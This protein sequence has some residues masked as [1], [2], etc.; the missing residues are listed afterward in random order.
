MAMNPGANEAVVGSCDHGLKVIDVDKVK[1]KRELY[2]KKYGHAEWVTSVTYTRDGRVLS[3]GMD[4]KLC[5]WDARAVK[6]SDLTGHTASISKVM[7][8]STEDIAISSSYDKTLMVWDTKSG[9]SL[10]TPVNF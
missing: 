2:N 3:A 7:A 8:S 4:S 5:L 9:R 10:G 6:C 1:K